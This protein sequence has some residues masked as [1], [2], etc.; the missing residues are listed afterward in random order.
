MYEL[1]GFRVTHAQK[2]PGPILSL[3]IAPDC[4][5]LAVGQADGLLCLRKHSAPRTAAIVA[6]GV[7]ACSLCDG[8]H[9]EVP[10]G[11]VTEKALRSA[12]DDL[13]QG[14][15]AASGLQ[16]LV[17]VGSGHGRQALVCLCHTLQQFTQALCAGGLYLSGLCTLPCLQLMLQRPAL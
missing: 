17:Q 14:V 8:K 1:E 9:V 11:L 15:H 3:D 10:Q 2:Y 13:C 4:S 5:A 6:G 7:S 12:K 16:R